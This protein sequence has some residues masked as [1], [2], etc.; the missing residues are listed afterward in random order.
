MAKVL[1][2]IDLNA[3]FASAEELRHPEWKDEPLGIGSNSARGVLS[4]C[5]YPA[6]A[7][8][9]HSAMPVMQALAMVPDLRL[10]PPDHEYYR[11][12]SNQFFQYIR[13]Y[14]PKIEILSIDECFADVTEIIGK[15]PR[16]LD[17]AVTLQQGVYKEL[18]LKCSIGVGPTRFL[19]KMASDMHKPMGLTVLRKR[20]IPSKLYPLPVEACIGVGAKTVPRLKEAGI[21]TIGDLADPDNE[22]ICEQIFKNS[23]YDLKRR[24]H[25]QSSDEL[26]YSTTRKSISHSR[27]F[28]SDLYSIE[29]LQTQL[30]LLIQELCDNM[31]RKHKKGMQVSLVLR[32]GSFRNKVRSA[33]LSGYTND[34]I[35]INEAVSGL[36]YQ[37]F[38]PVGYRHIGVS[39]GSL[40]DEDKII[41]QPSLFD[42]PQKVCNSVLDDLNA[43]LDGGKLMHLGDLLKEKEKET[44]TKSDTKTNTETAQQGQGRNG[45]EHE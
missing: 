24:I 7:L 36:L 10:V 41:V 21:E 30:H 42:L 2:H 45:K 18:G 15:F 23:W 3:F 28:P 31:Q 27:T 33:K 14:C 40:Q 20:D 26:I 5:N 35:V 22:A 1:F 38:E 43:K 13:R 32:D 34:P 12:L 4:T 6:R 39:V 29:D 25:G 8:G 37:E 16:P 44:G 11:S 9:L 17:L 19:A